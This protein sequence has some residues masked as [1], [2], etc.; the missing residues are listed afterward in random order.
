MSRSPLGGIV[1]VGR[2]HVAVGV[3]E[4]L[5]PRHERGGV[6]GTHDRNVGVKFVETVVTL[7]LVVESHDID[8]R[9][10]IHR[11]EMAVVHRR[12]HR[13]VG[14]EFLNG[15]GHPPHHF[16]SLLASLH[17]FLVEDG[18][19]NHGGVVAVPAHHPSELF[20]AF[21]RA[22][23]IAVLVHHEHAETVAGVQ[24]LGRG[25]VVRAAVG[26]GAHLLEFAD[27]E[28]PE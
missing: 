23:K 22:V 14:I 11:I 18:P 25:R 4:I 13:P 21:R 5:A 10:D 26:V 8:R 9:G 7:L 15:R 20:H 24:K 27:A 17:R 19:E 12:G 16:V 1:V 6:L 28:V 2:N 3:G